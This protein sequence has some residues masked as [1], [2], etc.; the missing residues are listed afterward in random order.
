MRQQKGSLR[1]ALDDLGEMQERFR[2]L[3]EREP[4]LTNQIMLNGL[5]NE[6]LIAIVRNGINGFKDGGK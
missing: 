5:F 6:P 3:A 1:K 4:D 2:A